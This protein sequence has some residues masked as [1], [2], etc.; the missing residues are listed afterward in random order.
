M[1]YQLTVG[2]EIHAELRT[3]TKIFCRCENR[4]GDA[5]NRNVCPV[6]MGMPGALPVFNRAVSDAAVRLGT[7][8]GCRIARRSTF[9][10]KNYFYPDNPAGYQITQYENPIC[11]GGSV[12]IFDGAVRIPLIRIHMEEDAAKLRHE[13]AVTYADG[14]RAGV[15]LLE[16]VS[17]PAMHSAEEAEAYVNALREI[18]TAL[19]ISDCKMQNGSLR[20]DVN[21]S[22]APEGEIGEAVEIKNI[23]S[24][25]FMKRAISAEFERQCALLRAGERIVRQTRRFS[26]KTGLTEPMR[27]KET[28][29]DYRY[30]PEPDLPPLV[31]TE[32]E[33][34]ALGIDLPIMPSE[35]RKTLRVLGLTE[36]IA[37]E[38]ARFEPIY[39]LL[40]DAAALGADPISAANLLR[41]VLFPQFPPDPRD[42]TVAALLRQG[43]AKALAEVCRM[44][45]EGEVSAGSAAKL[46]SGFFETGEDPG[47]VAERLCMRLVRE[48][49]TLLSWCR[50][51][52]AEDPAL[53][54]SYR[55]EER[56]AAD[57][58]I[59]AVIR[60]SGGRAAPAVLRSLVK[61]GK[62]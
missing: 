45:T 40:T 4:F 62:I 42:D 47:T 17:E 38:L 6:C 57:R 48:E 16:I 12:P 49:E 60:Y 58:L 25:R 31:Y 29:P 3:K 1:V 18:L 10:R 8:L 39:T 23:N 32:D 28:A 13:G 7:V 56:G 44:L 27:G 2:L 46:L 37:E 22:A 15:P 55:K 52:L 61:E 36:K 59:G 24:V 5:E 54:L 11:R 26:E 21:V 41:G 53:A 9:D 51:V 34:R 35:R 30:F 50:T 20:V 33:I 14:N 19:G 43:S